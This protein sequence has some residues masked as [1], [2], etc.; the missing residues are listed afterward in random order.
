MTDYGGWT[1]D[2]TTILM[3]AICK[4]TSFGY[5]IEDGRKDEKELTAD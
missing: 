2:I 3:M 1:L 4:F 5:C